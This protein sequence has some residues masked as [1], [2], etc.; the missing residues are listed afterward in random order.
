MLLTS[1][2]I[3]QILDCLFNLI[4]INNTTQHLIKQRR[5]VLIAFSNLY[6]N[7][8][9]HSLSPFNN[10]EDL[11]KKLINSFLR[12]TRDYT[13]DRFGDSGRLVRETACTQ[14]VRL[15]KAIQSNEQTKYFLTST[16]LHQCLNAILANV[17]SKIDDLRM[18]SGK[19]L[20][21]FLNIDFEQSIENKN[22][23]KTIFSNIDSID[24]RNAQVVF[25][26]VVQLL[27]Y[28]KYRSIIWLNCLLTAGELGNASQALY[29]YLIGHQTNHE[30]IRLLFNDLE[31]IFSDKQTQQMRILIPCIQACERLLS[32]STFENF[33]RINTDEFIRYWM[34]LLTSFDDILQKKQ[35]ILNNNPTLYLHFIKLYCSLLQF[36]HDKFRQIVL[37]TITKCFLHNY[38]WVRR[39]AA[40]NLYDTCIMYTDDFFPDDTDDKS[41]QVLN[42][43]TETD[44][45]QNFDELTRIRQTLLNLFRN[46]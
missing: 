13:N 40:Q 8:C 14:L 45:E 31:K 20:V 35:Q 26:L 34:N 6:E 42:L 11:I 9:L 33:S 29:S 27:I 38:P 24:W 16:V 22:E 32:Q 17:C 43:L 5:D 7:V 37:E 19:A 46:E 4:V 36:N 10:N 41:E 2:T 23:L 18:T 28:D 1:Q 3:N 12:C 44:W 30:L 39:Q 25:S 15:I 21:E